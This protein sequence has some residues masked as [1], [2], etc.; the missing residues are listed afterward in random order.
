MASITRVI[1][2]KLFLDAQEVFFSISLHLHLLTTFHPNPFLLPFPFIPPCHPV[3]S[4][5]YL[6]CAMLFLAPTPLTPAGTPNY[7]LPYPEKLIHPLGHCLE[8][9]SFIK[10]SVTFLW[11]SC[12]HSIIHSFI[13]KIFM[14]K[15]L[16]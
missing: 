9:T 14:F 1:T 10:P 6:E 15:T 8:V 3:T 11:S 5:L 13:Q 16:N 2:F 12:I 7:T 4:S